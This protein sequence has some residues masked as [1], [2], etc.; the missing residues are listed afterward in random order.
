[1]LTPSVLRFLLRQEQLL[2]RESS[3]VVQWLVC[4][5]LDPRFAG[6]KPSEGGGFLKAIKNRSTPSD[7]YSRRP[8]V[9]R[10]YGVLNIPAELRERYY[11]G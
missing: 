11:I 7:K 4:L 10:F 5:L 2:E 9:V 6:S 8:H 3:S 1:M